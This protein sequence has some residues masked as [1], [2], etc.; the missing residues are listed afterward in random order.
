MTKRTM[1][2]LVDLSPDLLRNPVCDID[3]TERVAGALP[4]LPFRKGAGDDVIS[5]AVLHHLPDSNT[6]IQ[7]LKELKRIA[8]GE[9]VFTV[10]RRW[11]RG[12]KEAILGRIKKGEPYDDLVDHHRPWKDSK[13]D[14][15]AY[16]FYHYYTFKE[17]LE[18]TRDAGLV[19]TKWKRMGGRKSDANFLVWV[20]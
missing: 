16:R 2:V 20:I 10:W 12:H 15:I 18:E 6:R 1:M 19:I 7:A 4:S 8:T 14:V 13:G 17:L 9:I 11:R 5:I 3:I